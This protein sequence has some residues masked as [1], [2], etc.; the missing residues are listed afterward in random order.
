MSLLFGNAALLIVLH[1]SSTHLT[2]IISH[3]NSSPICDLLSEGNCLNDRIKLAIEERKTFIH[4]ISHVRSKL[5]YDE[6]TFS[7]KLVEAVKFYFSDYEDVTAII[8]EVL[9]QSS[10]CDELFDIYHIQHGDDDV[11]TITSITFSQ[12]K[13][14]KVWN[15]YFTTWGNRYIDVEFQKMRITRS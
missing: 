4:G 2:N 3:V 5:L 15:L 14:D 6:N 11:T 13:T 8:L 7:D 10:T 1:R 12:V 9:K